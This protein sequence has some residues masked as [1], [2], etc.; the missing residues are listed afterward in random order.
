MFV[1]YVLHSEEGH[2]YI[3]QTSDLVRRLT[4][5]NSHISH[6]TRHGNNWKVIHSEIFE[7]RSDAMKREKYFKTGKGREELKNII[8]GVESAAAE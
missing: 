6:S 8:R 3:G 5:H 4:E 1:V 2:Q 7:S